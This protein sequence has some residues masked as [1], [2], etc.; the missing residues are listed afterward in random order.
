MKHL[1]RDYGSASDVF[2]IR[3]AYDHAYDRASDRLHADR[4]ESG[5]TLLISTNPAG[6]TRSQGAAA[7]STRPTTPRASNTATLRLQWFEWAV[8]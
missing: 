7:P 4:Q 1:W 3:H 2:D 5:D 8:G 6:L